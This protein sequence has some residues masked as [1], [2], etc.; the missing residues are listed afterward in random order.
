MAFLSLGLCPNAPPKG[1]P[2]DPGIAIVAAS[3]SFAIPTLRPPSSRTA[4]G[5]LRSLWKPSGANPLSFAWIVRILSLTA[6]FLILLED[7]SPQQCVNSFAFFPLNFQLWIAHPSIWWYDRK[8]NIPKRRFSYARLH[9]Q[10]QRDGNRR[11]IVYG[12]RVQLCA[13]ALDAPLARP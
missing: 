12:S 11:Q 9:F 5:G 1:F 7:F 2:I 4:C 6:P 8:I 10:R 3:C 13:G